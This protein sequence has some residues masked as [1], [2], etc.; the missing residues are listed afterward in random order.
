M[1]D[2]ADIIIVGAGPTGLTMALELA[3]QGVSFRIVD[4]AEKASDKSRALAMHARSLEVLS[5]HGLRDDLI[6]AG[7]T[8]EGM[9]IKVNGKEVAKIQVDPKTA[10]FPDAARSLPILINQC[11]TETILLRGLKNKY[12]V[13]PERG[14]TVADIKPDKD[15]VSLTLNGK[16]VRC[17]YVVGADGAHSVVRH[18]APSMTFEGAP[19][20]QDFTLCDAYIRP[21]PASHPLNRV[22][23]CLGQG[24]L[25]ALPLKGEN[26]IRLVISRAGRF[27]A[28]AQSKEEPTL[29][30]FQE[31]LDATV[32]GFGELYDPEWL[33]RFHLH[34]RGVSTYRDGR[35]FVAGD[36]AH[37]HSPVGGQGMNTGIQDAA[38]LGWKLAAAVRHA[39]HNA[40][41]PVGADNAGNDTDIEKLLDSY[42]AERFPIG[43]RLLQ[44]TDYMFTWITWGNPI[45][46]ALRNALVPWVLPYAMASSA[47]KQTKFFRYIT[48]LAIRYARS[49]IVG[50]GSGYDGP[51][52]G[53]YRAPDGRV[54]AVPEKS[55]KKAPET[56]LLS[57]VAGDRHSLLLFSGC[58]SGAATPEDLE[59][60]KQ[61]FVN[62]AAGT[63]LGAKVDVHVIY[64][65]EAAAKSLKQKAGDKEHVDAEDGAL[66]ERY[67]FKDKAGYAYVRPDLYIAH[68]GYLKSA[69]D[70]LLESLK[71][72][73]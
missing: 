27:A 34:H 47:K 2:N 60:V 36:A 25:V 19:Y 31:F 11:E 53:G 73:A 66:H 20:P 41:R 56:W 17:K 13:E 18:S 28:D 6:N 24:L 63:E 65:R 12:N 69:V 21:G 58:G 1:S 38:N 70:E 44:S 37:I 71:N 14:V 35:L 72:D 48:Q 59:S 64:S 22:H 42:H 54:T 55:D 15:G 52:K 43:Q 16:P 33:T 8:P 68:I 39:D 10:Q 3:L 62:A 61:R 7:N 9:S 50:T 45:F 30:D 26:K 49:A 23:F 40:A 57:S 51:V 46:L 4:K 32:P 29:R 67:G 5:R